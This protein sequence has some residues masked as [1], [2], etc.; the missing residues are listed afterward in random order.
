METTCDI[1]IKSGAVLTL[2]GHGNTYQ[3]GYLAITGDVI[4][5]VGPGEPPPHLKP[6]YI[7]PAQGHLVMPGLINAHTHAAMTL[8]RGLA[9]DLPLMEW[10]NNYIF[11]GE[12]RLDG[13]TVYIG[14]L[15]ACLE[16]IKSGT[17]T[18]CDMY[19]F[20]KEV[21]KAAEKAGVRAVVGEVI[22]DF[23]SPNYG[24]IERGFDYTLELIQEYRGH[25]LIT[26]AIEPHSV[27]TCGEDL[28]L[29]AMDMARRENVMMITHLSE[30]EAEVA[31]SLEQHGATPIR[32]LERL[33]VLGP[34]LLAD[35]VVAV[36]DEELDL[37]AERQVR[38]AHNPESNMKLANGVAPVPKM[39][40]R[41]MA[42][43]LGTDGCASNNNLNM[44]QEMDITAK[45]H[46]LAAKDPT[47]MGAGAVLDLATNGSA[48]AVGLAHQ[49]GSLE[50]GKKADVIILD[51]DHP[52]LT[53]LYNLPSHLVYSA[54]G[55]EVTTVIINGRLVMENGR[56]LTLDQGAIMA[57]ARAI[58]AKMKTWL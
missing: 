12:A 32:H 29:K 54:T 9:D 21:A 4:T 25:D 37:L 7:I 14:S 55:G 34:H 30:S 41:G 16:M 26:P 45:L 28:F 52:H 8:F 39:L 47:V 5:D 11:P 53:P 56:I 33:G 27:Y 23:P 1:L 31:Q 17:T 10:L 58:G 3:P 42:V 46:K 35:H 15:L 57:E 43:G 44:F 50:K 48:A 19:L 13:H 2:D 40:Q 51:M 18:F 49:I 6:K 38:V 22:Y 36:S 20:E 24:P